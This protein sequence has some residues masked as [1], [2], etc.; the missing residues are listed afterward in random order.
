M[1]SMGYAKLQSVVDTLF[2]KHQAR[3]DGPLVPADPVVPFTVSEIDSAVERAGSKNKAPGPD[4]ISGKILWVVH[5]AH[6]Y[7]LL[8]LYN[9]CLRSGTLPA[10]WKTS[11][12][13][14][15]KGT[16]QTVC[17]FLTASLAVERRRQSH[18]VPAH[19]KTR[20]PH[21]GQRWALGQSVWL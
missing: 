8:D 17:P 4:G 1:A 9:S 6:P 16:S 10:D 15:R 19:T 12:V 5:K 13:V 11:R 7:I 2:P 3:T 20:G 14:L 21:V 18:R